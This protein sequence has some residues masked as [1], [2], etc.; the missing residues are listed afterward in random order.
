MVCLVGCQEDRGAGVGVD[1][2]TL[3]LGPLLHP[4][5]DPGNKS[6]DLPQSLD[7]TWSGC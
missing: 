7:S 5:V 6:P 1:A 3:A 2:V 4:K